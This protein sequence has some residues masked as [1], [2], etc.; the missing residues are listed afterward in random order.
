MRISL[1]PKEKGDPYCFDADLCFYLFGEKSTLSSHK[2]STGPLHIS[3]R[4]GHSRP[5]SP[6]NFEAGGA[7]SG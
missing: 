1:N 7:G 6:V 3:P 4:C 5:W 2:G